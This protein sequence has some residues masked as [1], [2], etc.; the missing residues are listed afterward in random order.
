[1]MTIGPDNFERYSERTFY[2]KTVEID[3]LSDVASLVRNTADENNSYSGIAPIAFFE[4]NKEGHIDVV[5]INNVYRSMIEERHITVERFKRYL[6][7]KGNLFNNTIN[8]LIDKCSA[9]GYTSSEIMSEGG[10]RLDIR[11]KRLSDDANR[12][13]YALVI[14][15]TDK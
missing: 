1:M 14:A 2:E 3:F 15:I 11:V 9:L 6:S 7:E 13:L 8:E 12:S 10:K 4:R 5:F